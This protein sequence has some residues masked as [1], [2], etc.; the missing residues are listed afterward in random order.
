MISTADHHDLSGLCEA[1]LI[2]GQQKSGPLQPV[3][4]REGEGAPVA[5][6]SLLAWA[7]RVKFHGMAPK[8]VSV[9]LW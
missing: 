5:L 7:V 6:P 8:L 4:G 1:S 3:E 2:F 9:L